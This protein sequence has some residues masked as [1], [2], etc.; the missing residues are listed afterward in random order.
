MSLAEQRYVFERGR[1]GVMFMCAR[2]Y[3][4]LFAV[5]IGNV[6]LRNVVTVRNVAL[7]L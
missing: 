3:D 6:A 5:T 2:V 7:G 4:V 1:D